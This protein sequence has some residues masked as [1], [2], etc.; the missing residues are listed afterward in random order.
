MGGR[1]LLKIEMQTVEMSGH[2]GVRWGRVE[3]GWGVVCGS[4]KC[5]VKGLDWRGRERG[6]WCA[7]VFWMSSWEREDMIL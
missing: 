3:D 4:T 5:W 6:V 2:S 7:V 1:N